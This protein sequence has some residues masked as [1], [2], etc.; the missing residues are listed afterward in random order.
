MN[1]TGLEPKGH[2]AEKV[3][4]LDPATGAVK[5]KPALTSAQIFRWRRLFTRWTWHWG[6]AWSRERRHSQCSAWS[7]Q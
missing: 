1:A 3:K 4:F 6:C 7:G 5:H 2:V